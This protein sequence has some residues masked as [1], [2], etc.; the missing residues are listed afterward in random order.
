MTDTI[1]MQTLSSILFLKQFILAPSGTGVLIKVMQ[2]LFFTG[3]LVS[4]NN[5]FAID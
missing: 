4:V 5:R 1:S 2:D 3:R